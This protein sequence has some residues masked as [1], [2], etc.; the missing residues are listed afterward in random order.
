MGLVALNKGR[1]AD[2]AQI[3]ADQKRE[4]T[5]ILAGMKESALARHHADNER[6]PSV[7]HPSEM[8]KD[9]W[10]VRATYYRMTGAGYL[11]R[12][13]NWVQ[14]NI[15]AFGTD[16]HSYFQ[17]LL[18][19]TGE[20]FGDWACTI[21][22]RYVK[23]TLS[24]DLDGKPCAYYLDEEGKSRHVNHNW[25]YM[26]IP[27]RGGPAGLISG[28]ADAGYRDTIGEFKT[29]GLGT[30]R[31]DAPKLASKYYSK[32]LAQYD[33]D[34]LWKDLK[35]PLPS[36]VRQGN[37]YLYLAQAMGYDFT[38]VTYVYQFKP[39]QQ[40]REFRVTYSDEIMAPLLVRANVIADAIYKDGRPPACEFGGCEQCRAYEPKESNA[41]SQPSTEPDREAGRIVQ[42]RSARASEAG[43]GRSSGSAGEQAADAPR[44]ANRP[45]RPRADEAA[46][47]ARQVGR[48]PRLSEER[49]GSG[50][51]VRSESGRANGRSGS[52]SLEG[53]F[54]RRDESGGLGERRVLRGESG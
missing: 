37:T 52:D 41:I 21:C 45:E 22:G 15:F 8:A 23:R 20:L 13:F 44:G 12:D 34:G 36:H 38:S 18:Q 24:G 47:P 6:D 17:A 5:S 27:L 2:L 26:E 48:V 39:N 43:S 54:R 19:E 29:V 11:T 1:L 50:R 32:E 53:R 10:C 9:D 49:R 16:T 30:I 40:T 28:K 35:R 14:E 7:I 25:L 33:I 42:R 3:R 51:T 4:H 46:R 31:V